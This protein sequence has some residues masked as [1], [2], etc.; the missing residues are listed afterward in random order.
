MTEVYIVSRRVDG[1]TLI[2]GVYQD[3]A[4]AIEDAE[5]TIQKISHGEYDFYSVDCQYASNTD[6]GVF[7]GG[8]WRCIV[9]PFELR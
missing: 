1:R 8:E 5:E 3:R 9:Y 2:A 6:I 7:T 4:D